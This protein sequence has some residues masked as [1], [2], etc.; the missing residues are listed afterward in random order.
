[1]NDFTSLRNETYL[2]PSLKWMRENPPTQLVAAAV[3]YDCRIWTGRRHFTL[4]H[5]V[6]EDTKHKP[7]TQEMQGFICDN[8]LF[9][10]TTLELPIR[11]YC[12][13]FLYNRC[14]I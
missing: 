11:S 13:L 8:G 9:V 12:S 1:M 14:L 10:N 4:I 6:V 3:L 7:V 2:R 5:Q